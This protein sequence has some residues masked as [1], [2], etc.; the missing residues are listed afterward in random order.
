MRG[1]CPGR[2][3]YWN[4]VWFNCFPVRRVV[5]DCE[6]VPEGGSRYGLSSG[7]VSRR[8]PDHGRGV[9]GP[10]RG[11][12]TGDDCRCPVAARSSR[13]SRRLCARAYPGRGVCRFG[14]RVVGS[15]GV[16]SRPA[17]AAQ[18]GGGAGRGAAVGCSCGCPERGVR[19]LEPCGVGA[20]LVGA[21]GGGYPS[22][23]DS[24]WRAGGVGCPYAISH[25]TVQTGVHHGSWAA[26]WGRIST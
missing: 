17:S 21:A 12:R 4:Q 18:G 20:C 9:G 16:R 22:C 5:L 24:R 26:L 2:G 8:D 1:C 23:P 7:I 10:A 13:W 19:R 15:F 3:Q 11:G 14:D 25:S 6:H